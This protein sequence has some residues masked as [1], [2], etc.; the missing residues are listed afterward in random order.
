MIDPIR[1]KF[2]LPGI[3]LPGILAL[4]LLLVISI[5]RSNAAELD[6]SPTVILAGSLERLQVYPSE[7][8]LSG[9]RESVQLVVSGVVENR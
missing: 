5:P 8:Q 9:P 1:Q 4:V 7:F 3:L 2:Q 6:A